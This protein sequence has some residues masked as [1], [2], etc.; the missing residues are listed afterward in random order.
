MTNTDAPLF[1]AALFDQRLAGNQQ[2]LAQFREALRHAGQTQ[3]ERFENGMS[4]SELVKQRAWLMDQLITRAWQV[5]LVPGQVEQ[6]ALV[7]VGGY[8][9]G[10]LHPCSDID[11]MILLDDA[12]IPALADA[13]EKF[14]TLLWDIGLEVGHSVRTVAECVNLAQADITIATNLME[15]RLLCGS[16]PLFTAMQRDTD[17]EHIWPGHQFFA[18]K[19]Q[20]QIT[21]H[22]KF[23]NTAYN[24]EPNIKDGPGGLR[25]I[26]VI[27]W[28]AKRHFAAQTLHEL[29]DHEFLTAQ[30]YQQLIKGQEFLWRIRIALHLLT[31]RREDR[32]L[33]DHQRTLAKQFGYTDHDHRLAVEHFMKDYYRTVME[34]SRLNDMLLQLF[35]EEIL[36]ADESGSIVPLNERFQ[37]RKGFIEAVDETVFTRHPRA[38]L[39]IFLLLEQ[40]S[41]LKGIRAWTARL[42]RQ[43]RHL[44]NDDFRSNPDNT[45]LFMEILRQPVGITHEL[46]RMHRYGILA[47]YLPVFGNIVGQMQ[48]DLFHVYTVDEHTL[49][50]LRNVRR[51]S[52]PEYAHEFPLCSKRFHHI[53]RPELLYIAALFHDI[54]KGRGGDHSE[55]GAADA[56]RFCTDHGLGQEDTE[57]VCWLIRHH[58]LMSRTAQHKDLSDP[59]VINTFAAAIQSQARLDHLYL[60]TVA[61]IRATSPAVWNSW[62]DALLKELF[63]ATSRALRRGLDKPL[64]QGERIEFTKKM[65]LEELALHRIN[66][67]QTQAVWDKVG[68]D[69]F[70]IHTADE[71]AWQT[72]HIVKVKPEQL[73]LIAIRQMTRRGGT[74]IFLYTQDRDYLFARATAAL[75][76]ADLNIVD[77]R[78]ITSEDGHILDTFIV[79]DYK[80][81]AISNRRQLH[82]I[83]NCLKKHLAMPE[84]DP[85]RIHKRVS[86]QLKHFPIPTDV[87]FVED[88]AKQR[89]IMKVVTSD[90]PGLLARIGAALW[91]CRIRLQ[92]A[93]IA[94]FGERVEDI[95]FITDHDH[96]PLREPA[97]FE[98]LRRAVIEQLQN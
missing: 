98:Q 68:A 9:R 20:E 84:S 14:L 54:A 26:Q 72:R 96:Q 2:P 3:R 47:A 81:E 88:S 71:I 46:R 36:Y 4:A 43:H 60:L 94:T 49:F 21:R 45:A 27:G 52:V 16:Q 35:K 67:Q 44:I 37:T 97:Q 51:F 41:Q 25:D 70:L 89:T 64:E 31:G 30:E 12:D 73:P 63:N 40:N 74:E 28:V 50:V 59:K 5:Q 48:H 34:L 8:G 91:Q 80:G 32:L 15:A 61:D 17:A 55:L 82:E 75:E 65:A 33:F 42:I 93:K 53:A 23:N 58:L 38:L 77:A 24:L 85:P 62:K 66:A 10:E 92:N 87:T 57:L 79:L 95:F 29:L 90:R 83:E 56:H 22:G 7:A 39:E 6:T 19:L 18:A 13:I 76:Q 11:L 69:Y 78:I 1:D 86:Q